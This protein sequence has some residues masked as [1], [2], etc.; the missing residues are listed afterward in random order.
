MGYFLK[1]YYVHKFNKVFILLVRRMLAEITALMVFICFKRAF[2]FFENVNCNT[3]VL[4]RRSF[5]LLNLI[6]K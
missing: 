1:F 6:V 3:A 2:A 5:L 4:L